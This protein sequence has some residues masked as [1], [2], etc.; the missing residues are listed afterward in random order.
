M[1]CIDQHSFH[2]KKGFLSFVSD[3]KPGAFAS[4]KRDVRAAGPLQQGGR[5]PDGSNPYGLRSCK[6][7][8]T[9]DNPPA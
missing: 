7:E 1:S 9:A 5:R 6:S 2:G 8:T 3:R 4:A